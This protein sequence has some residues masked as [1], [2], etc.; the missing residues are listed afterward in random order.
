M[1]RLRNMRVIEIPAFRAVSSGEGT[2]DEIFGPGGFDEWVG[3]HREL[4]FPSL[5]EPNNFLWHEEND[6]DRSV[7]IYPVR[8][9]VTEEDAK[10]YT[11]TEFRG[12]MYLAA[13]AD[14]LDEADINETVSDMYRWIGE[15]DVFVMGDYPV[16]GMCNMPAGG[17]EMDRRMGV[18]Q[19]QIFLPLKY[20]AE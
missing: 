1:S 19:Q 10:P 4:I 16:S 17:S 20:R 12:G 15:S 9:G 11:L 6:I 8:S 5:Y 14:E 18:A 3:A 7:L 2:L 13:T